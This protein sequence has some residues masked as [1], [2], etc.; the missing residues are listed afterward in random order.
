MSETL[1]NIAVAAAILIFAALVTQWFTRAMYYR[2]G[3]CGT[4]NAKR[5]DRCRDCGAPLP[6]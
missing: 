3:S 4:L 6:S 1:L 5:R 2:C